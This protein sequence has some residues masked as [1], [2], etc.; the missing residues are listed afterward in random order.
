MI[1]LTNEQQK[2][3]LLLTDAE[4]KLLRSSIKNHYKLGSCMPETYDFL[5][6]L[7]SEQWQTI[8]TKVSQLRIDNKQ[9]LKTL[10]RETR[11]Q[12]TKVRKT[13]YMRDYMRRYRL[14]HR[15]ATNGQVCNQDSS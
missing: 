2:K 4:W 1:N 13:E 14:Q 12:A 6:A 3:L 7:T 8:E 15:G 9:V 10:R 11:Q 5:L